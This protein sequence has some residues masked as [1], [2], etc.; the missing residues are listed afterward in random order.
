MLQR[1]ADRRARDAKLLRQTVLVEPRTGL[2]PLLMDQPDD[3][4]EQILL[5]AGRRIGGFFA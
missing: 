4:P 2:Q 3:Q 5:Q 1:G